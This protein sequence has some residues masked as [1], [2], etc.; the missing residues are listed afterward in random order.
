M[1]FDLNNFL[2][3]NKKFL[4]GSFIGAAFFVA[5]YAV[6]DSF[7]FDDMRSSAR[8]VAAVKARLAKE[9]LYTQKNLDEAR[10]QE[11][12]LN[13]SIKSLATK[14]VF[15]TRPEFMLKDGGAS[16]QNQYLDIA[17]RFREKRIDD[18]R[19]RGIDITDNCGVPDRSPT[20]PEDIRRTLRALDLADRV[21]E[22]A[23]SAG[24]RS[25]DRIQVHPDP[26][27]EDR[28]ESMIREEIKVEFD[29]E[30]SSRALSAF[31]EMTQSLNPPLT[32]DEYN[33]DARDPGGAGRVGRG[34]S[35]IRVTLKFAALDVAAAK[36]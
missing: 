3:E 33:S 7:V 14:L 23:I 30:S 5:G 20:Q 21:L 4:L 1:A 11:T 26:A 16:P 34:E 15:T 31:I 22:C 17:S 18:A 6:I 25:I 35:L 12:L 28:G 24:V 10:S 32:M 9:E 2:Q 27:R 13:D 8:D 19:S 29:M 36:E